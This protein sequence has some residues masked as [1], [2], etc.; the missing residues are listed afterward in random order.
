M[1]EAVV[2]GL[3]AGWAVALPVGAI[4]AYLVALS[5]SAP[6]R[7]GAAA[8][9]GVATADGLYALVAVAGGAVVAPLVTRAAQ[10]L[11]WVSAVVLLG[12]AALTIAR[13]LRPACAAPVPAPRGAFVR[14]LGLTLVNPM[15]IVA[16]SALVV[17]ARSGGSPLAEQLVFAA[18]AFVASASWQLLLAGAG[19]LLGATL[20]GRRGRLAT[21]LVS[22]AVITVLA[23]DLV[24]G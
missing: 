12:L 3:L 1:T 4:G 5:A 21:S 19:G 20:T 18:S 16:F 11:R 2:A 22:S 7:T 10:P 14:L 24:G 6:W 9:L 17:G 15:T 23:L 8:A 13:A